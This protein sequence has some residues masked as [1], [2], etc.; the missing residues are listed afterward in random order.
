MDN[1]QNVNVRRVALYRNEYNTDLTIADFEFG[2]KLLDTFPAVDSGNQITKAADF[3]FV[4]L[5]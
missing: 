2:V 4:Y 5:R 3:G 1:N